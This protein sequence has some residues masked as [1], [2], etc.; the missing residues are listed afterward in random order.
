[1][2]YSTSQEARELSHIFNINRENDNYV[3][4]V[5]LNNYQHL[6]NDWDASSINQKEL[7]PELFDFIE[8]AS[9]EIPLNKEHELWFYLPE[10]NRDERKEAKSK[11]AIKNNFKME[12]YFIKKKLNRIYRKAITYI[13]MGIIFLLA[14]YF[15]PET[16]GNQLLYS[17]FME[18]IFIGGWVFLWEAFSQF[19]FASHEIRKKRKYYQRFLNSRLQFK[20]QE[21]EDQL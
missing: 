13:M 21:V 6:Y 3:I 1:M 16:A 14:A 12:L 5:N 7:A 19:F 15:L 2:F 18:G 9:Y 8:R 20:Y 4:E 10:A 11:K 17:L